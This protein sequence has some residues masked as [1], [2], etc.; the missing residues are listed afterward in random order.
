MIDRYIY[1]MNILLI[2]REI[3]NQWLPTELRLHSIHTGNIGASSLHNGMFISPFSY[4]NQFK[5]NP[6]PIHI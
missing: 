1:L 2:V 6:L 5:A 3:G 4:F